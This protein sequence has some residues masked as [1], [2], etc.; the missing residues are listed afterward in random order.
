[1]RGGPTW[2]RRRRSVSAG[3]VRSAW[4]LLWRPRP[5]DVDIASR[6][7]LEDPIETRRHPLG[8]IAVVIAVS[9]IVFAGGFF[10]RLP[11]L[12]GLSSTRL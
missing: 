8:V 1:M 11:P 2:R 7:T 4:P 9:A 5:W 6:R 12:P 3:V 10:L